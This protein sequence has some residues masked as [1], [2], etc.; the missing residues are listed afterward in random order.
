MYSYRGPRG[1]KLRKIRAGPSSG[2]KAWLLSRIRR[3]VC[4][5]ATWSS[6]RLDSTSFVV[7]GRPFMSL[8]A[9]TVNPLAHTCVRQISRSPASSSDC[10]SGTRSP[11]RAHRL[12]KLPPHGRCSART[13]SV[14]GSIRQRQERFLATVKHA[15]LRACAKSLIR[16]SSCVVGIFLGDGNQDRGAPTKCL[17]ARRSTSRA[18]YLAG[19][20]FEAADHR[21]GIVS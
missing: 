17:V 12:P 3:P 6:T 13:D 18:A 10:R 1:Q 8:A 16:S 7:D 11:R 19:N 14:I 21:H 20:L 9:V 5:L 4:G 15:P 2:R